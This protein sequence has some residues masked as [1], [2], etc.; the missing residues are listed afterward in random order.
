MKLIKLSL[1]S[2]EKHFETEDELK[3]ELF[4]HI[5]NVCRTGDEA[6]EYGFPTTPVNS[7]SSIEEMLA[8]PCGCEF[9][10]N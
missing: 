6:K 3:K 2:W 1:E 8:S 10:V 7:E 5:C 4:K 9:D